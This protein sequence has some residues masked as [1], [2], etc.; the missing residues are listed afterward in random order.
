MQ[1]MLAPQ[2]TAMEDLSIKDKPIQMICGPL[3]RYMEID[4]HNRVWRGSC[5]IVINSFRPPSLTLLLRSNK[6]NR[7][8]IIYPDSVETIDI[9]RNEYYFWRYELL[10]PLLEEPQTVSYTSDSFTTKQFQF[11][12][13]A[14]QDSMRFMFYSCSGFSDIPQV[15]KD[16]FGE[17]EA[18]LWQD[19]LDRHQVMPFHVMLGGGDQ[20]YQ[21]RLI[22]EDFMKPWI[23]ERMPARRLAMK[24]PQSMRDGFE[25][26]YFWNYV[27]NFGFENNP[28]QAQ[29][30]AQIPSVN[31]WDDHDI[32]DGYGSYP[33]DMQSADCFQV[34]F[35][36]ASRFYYAFQHHTSIERAERDG[37]IRGNLPT[38]QHIL[39]TLG[40]SIGL[41]SLDA[42]GERTKQQV[43][44]QKSYDILFREMYKRMPPTVKHFMVLTGVPLIYPRLTLFEKAMESAASFNLA[45]LAGKTGTLGDIISGQLNEW[46]GDPELLDDMNDHWTAGNHMVERRDFIKKLQV[47][48][49]E[50]SIRVSFLGGDVHCCGA[51]RLYSKDMKTKEEG[52][53]FLMIQIVSSAIVNVPPPQA[54]LTVLN[55]NSSYETFDGNVEERMYDLFKFSP[56]GNSRTNKKLMGMRNYCAGYF[57]ED[58]GRIHFY[59][60]AEKEVGIKGTKG[61]LIAVPKLLFGKIGTKLHMQ[62]PLE[63]L[64]AIKRPINSNI[65]PSPPQPS[66]QPQFPQPQFSQ[67]Q[68]SQQQENLRGFQQSGFAGGFIRPPRFWRSYCQQ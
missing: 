6:T 63:Y 27:Q 64:N 30:Y 53:P 42:R 45:T 43:C 58:T 3:L 44:T 25:H 13:P 60:Q 67:Q 54:L 33:A 32:I 55:Q 19:V 4:Y 7:E 5:L 20:L 11:H 38:C 48:S 14:I 31:M 47:F 46:N 37:M 68:F 21:D 1:S 35:A 41:L 16:K 8:Q 52:D 26:F 28:I 57:E 12:L 34:L 51:G 24:L 29:A 18:P 62:S 50:K 10:L 56:N 40:P 2:I 59:I 61:Y 49:K 66:Q 65:P 36:N 23:A 39:T 22:H 17:K 9:F 15:V